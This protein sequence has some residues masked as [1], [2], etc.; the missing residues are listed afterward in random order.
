MPNPYVYAY[1]LILLE[2]L[3][4]PCLFLTSTYTP[5]VGTARLSPFVMEDTKA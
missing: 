2:D 3:T 1:L 4:L 5:P